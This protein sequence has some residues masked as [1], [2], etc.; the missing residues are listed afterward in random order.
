M[1]SYNTS[2]LLLRCRMR[3]GGS[4]QNGQGCGLVILGSDLSKSGNGGS[5]F[6]L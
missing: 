1:F 4:V 6:A 2:L 5:T 3:S